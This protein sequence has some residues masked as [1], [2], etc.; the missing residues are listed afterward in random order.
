MN[1]VVSGDVRERDMVRSSAI[2]SAL[3]AA[4]MATTLLAPAGEAMAQSRS[5]FC[6]ERGVVTLKVIDSKTIAAG[7][8]GGRTLALMQVAGRPM[9]YA[10]GKTSVEIAF[11]QKRIALR[12]PGEPK[13]D[14]LYPPP[15]GAGAP[16]AAGTSRPAV[17][18]SGAAPLGGAPTKPAATPSAGSGFA[19]KSWGGVVRSGPGME[20][21]QVA[22]L[23]EG[24]K[25]TVIEDAGTEMNGYR[26]FKIRFGANRVGYH[27]GGILCPIGKPVAG[28][29]Q[30]C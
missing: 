3:A 30:S 18:P 9:A 12:V 13:I 1:R 27:W 5:F 11:D 22:S 15:A 8:I 7:P 24:E 16:V 10:N 14:C 19:A 29:F 28:A 2:R 20:F 17:Q 21:K 23:K 25:I 4:A 26:W 6:G